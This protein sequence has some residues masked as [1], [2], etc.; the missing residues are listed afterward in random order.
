MI[1]NLCKRIFAVSLV[2][3]S[4][5]NTAAAQGTWTYLNNLAPNS[6]GGVMILLSDGSVITKTFDGGGDGNGNIWN[7][8]TPDST[9]SYVNGTWSTIAPMADTRTYF[10]LQMLR[11][12]KLYV[13][14]GEYG[15]GGPR[16]E[17]YD[18]VTDTWTPCGPIDADDTL[19]DANSMMLPDGRVLQSVVNSAT[20]GYGKKVYFYDPITN[21]YS[22][23][24]RVSGDFDESSW[25]MLPDNSVL[26]VDISAR[27][28]ERYIPAINKWKADANC[29]VLLYDIYLQETGPGL[30]LPDGR[31]FFLGANGKTALYTPS[32]DSTRGSWTIGPVI[33]DNN[34]APDAPAAMMPDG[35]I[36]CSV[37][38]KPHAPDSVFNTPTYFYEYSYANNAFTAVSSPDGNPYLDF[39]SCYTTNFL[40][41]PDGNVMFSAMSTDQYAIYTPAGTPL[42]AWKPAVS[43]VSKKNC[44]Y[45]ITGTQFNGISHGASYGDDWQMST[46][47]PIVRLKAGNRVYYCRTHDWNS[48]GVQRGAEP[49]TAFF[50]IPAGLP[51]GTYSLTVS[52]NGII[53]DAFNFTYQKCNTGVATLSR[54][55]IQLQAMPNPTTSATEISFSADRAGD[56]TI[57]VSDIFGRNVLRQEGKAIEGDNHHV[58][59]MGELTKGVYTAT[60]IKDRQSYAIKLVRD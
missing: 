38:P 29:P 37:S 44:E 18:P 39:V 46:N 49:D 2:L 43:T 1:S 4:L 17:V 27:S 47:Y 3:S 54:E 53:S 23:A 7:K 21:S 41:L 56:Y 51:E 19:V 40:T 57:T 34:G 11:S 24:P 8:L 33:P 30:L 32:G 26:F 5:C 31:A 9:G 25:V 55:Q 28:T 15:S 42:Q 22:P 14:G 10:S 48:S 52:A 36:L 58:L 13:A 16:G 20:L 60:L 12:G 50:A 35:N 59:N 45:M 6:N